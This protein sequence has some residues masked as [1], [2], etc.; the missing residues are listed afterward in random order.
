MLLRTRDQLGAG[1]LRLE[2]RHHGLLRI[3][4]HGH[5]AQIAG[6]R[7]VERR[8]LAQP[9]GAGGKHRE[10]FRRANARNRRCDRAIRYRRLRE[11]VEPQ[12]R[13]LKTKEPPPFIEQ[14]RRLGKRAGIRAAWVAYAWPAIYR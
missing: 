5:Q 3:G 9:R 7:I 12:Y 13:P 10:P 4:E 6:D 2:A 1:R 14:G 11:Y 8:K